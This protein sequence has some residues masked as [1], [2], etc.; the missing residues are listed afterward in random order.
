M[1]HPCDNCVCG[2]ARFD[3]DYRGSE[4][5]DR[6]CQTFQLGTSQQEWQRRSDRRMLSRT[7]LI[8]IQLA[9][10]TAWLAAII[11]NLFR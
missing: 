9:A 3:H 7:R 8:Y 10:V 5:G 1:T 11:Y 6:A 4:Y 2:W